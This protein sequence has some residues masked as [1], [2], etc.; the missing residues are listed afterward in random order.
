MHPLCDVRA[1]NVMKQPAVQPKAAEAQGPYTRPPASQDAPKNQLRTVP[2]DAPYS[3]LRGP[4]YY[5]DLSDVA[6]VV[7]NMS[8]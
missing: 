3:K 8:P 4:H 5:K 2:Q 7:K 6:E 1:V